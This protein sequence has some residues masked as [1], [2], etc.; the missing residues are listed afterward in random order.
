VRQ[1]HGVVPGLTSEGLLER[2]SLRVV[3]QEEV[4]LVGVL[5]LDEGP[6]ELARVEQAGVEPDLP[7]TRRKL[8][9]ARPMWIVI[10][11]GT[12]LQS[13]LLASSAARTCAC[14]TGA[15]PSKK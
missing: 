8:G 14:S 4:D 6:R 7:G 10:Y 15:P 12:R 13:K 11:V 2:R 3:E 1:R 5:M 9:I